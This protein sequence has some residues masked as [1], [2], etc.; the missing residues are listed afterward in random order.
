MCPACVAI[1]AMWTA[2]AASTGALGLVAA[3]TVLLKHGRYKR[4]L[5]I[6]SQ[7]FSIVQPGEESL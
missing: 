2:G 7:E 4:V 6:E 1:I 5:S 3:K